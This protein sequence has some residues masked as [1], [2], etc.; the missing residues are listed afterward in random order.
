MLLL[1]KKNLI[2]L[3]KTH[4]QSYWK[5]KLWKLKGTEMCTEECVKLKKNLADKKV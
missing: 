5:I 3:Y 1:A 2:Q 4:D